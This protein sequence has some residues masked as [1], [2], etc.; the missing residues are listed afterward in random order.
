MV[1]LRAYNKRCCIIRRY[2]HAEVRRNHK[3]LQGGR[4]GRPCSEG[5]KSRIQTY[6]IRV[7]TRAQRLRQDH[8]AQHHR[9]TR[10]IHRRRHVDRRS[11]HEKVQG[12][13]LGYIPQH[14]DRFCFSELQSDTASYD[15]RQRRDGDDALGRRACRAQETCRR[16]VAHRRAGRTD[17][18]TAQPAFG[19][20][21][22]ESFDSES[23]SQQSRD[24]PR[25]RAYGRTRQ[26]DERAGHGTSQ[27]DLSY[28]TRD[29]GHSQ[30][31]A[32]R[33]VFDAYCQR[34]GRRDSRR[35]DALRRQGRR[36]N[37]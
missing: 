34:Q 20:S 14:K 10:Q 30:P 2:H 29:H 3:R 1:R 32:C 17:E 37:R 11:L 21:D 16:G 22:A 7:H 6:R 25:G 28:Q 27:G 31:R 13:R 9:R 19:R 26:R 12:R 33:K 5:D 24:N 18:E 15:T 36:D 23:D 8:H 35:H 4:R